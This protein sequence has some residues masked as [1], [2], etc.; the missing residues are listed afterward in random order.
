MTSLAEAVANRR[1]LRGMSLQDV[2][3]EAGISKAHVFSIEQGRSKNPS[4][5][6]LL[7]L[8]C[9]LEVSPMQLAACAFADQPD[10]TTIPRSWRAS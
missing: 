6:T 9:A 3:D 4:A 2:A 1:A 5:S 10:V 8:A 7:G